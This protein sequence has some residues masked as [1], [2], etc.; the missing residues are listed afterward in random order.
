MIKDILKT[1]FEKRFIMFVL[2]GMV[3]VIFG[4]SAF[5]FFIFLNMH[6]AVASLIATCLGVIFNFQTLGKIV[7]KSSDNKLI[8]KF[9]LIYSIIYVVG[10]FFIK[11]LN[12]A[13]ENLYLCGG[14]S[15][16]FMAMLSY[17]L[18]RNFVFAKSIKQENE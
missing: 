4:Y 17:T 2:V 12:M 1:Y 14:I 9:I 16:I 5:A 10:V 11:A 6:Y 18:N 13:F 15:L 8:F 7:F 3:N